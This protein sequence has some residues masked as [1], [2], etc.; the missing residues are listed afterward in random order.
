MSMSTIVGMGSYMSSG[1][2]NST[3]MSMIIGMGDYTSAIT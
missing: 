2:N 1:V 3:S